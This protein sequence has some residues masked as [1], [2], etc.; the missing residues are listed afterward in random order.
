MP[1]VSSAWLPSEFVELTAKRMLTAPVP[2]FFYAQMVY[3]AD[4]R[5]QLAVNPGAFEWVNGRGIPAGLGEAVP[6]LDT[7]KLMLADPIRS[8]AIVVSDELAS[9]P[10]NVVKFNRPVFTGGGYTIASRMIAAGSS[11]SVT[12]L[13]ITGEQVPVEIVRLGG[14][15]ASGGSAVQPFGIDRYMAKRGVH[16]LVER[17]GAHLHYDRDA[18][19]DNVVATL[20]DSPVSTNILYPNDPNGSLSSDSSAFTANVNGD[21]PFDYETILRMEAKLQSLNIPRF[22]DGLYRLVVNPAQAVQLQMDPQ[23]ARYAKENP[24]TNP[25]QAGFLKRAGTVEV[26]MSNS[27]VV[28]TSTVSGVTINHAVMFGKEIVGRVADEEGCRIALSSDD[29]YGETAKAIWLAYE[30]YALLDNRFVCAA[31]SN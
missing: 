24:N 27:N 2:Q 28:D 23:F 13:A 29:N 22:D 10:G 14:P 7:M 8:G 17:V 16:S 11:I 19:I 26:Y 31:H 25:L 18:L 5:A 15:Y 30:G 20:F 9:Q 12:P 1:V 21:R 6:G 3:M 4:L